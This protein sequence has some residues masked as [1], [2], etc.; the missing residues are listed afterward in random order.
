MCGTLLGSG[1]AAIN[2]WPSIEQWPSP[3]LTHTTGCRNVW[4][5]NKAW[6][7]MIIKAKRFSVTHGVLLMNCYNPPPSHPSKKKSL[8]VT[9]TS[10]L[11]ENTF[12]CTCN[13]EHDDSTANTECTF[14]TW[15]RKYRYLFIC[16]LY[17]QLWSLSRPNH[18][19]ISPRVPYTTETLKA[20]LNMATTY[21]QAQCISTNTH[22]S[23]GYVNMP[24]Y[25]FQDISNRLQ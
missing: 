1:N 19:H 21:M 20:K 10:Y 11:Q 17:V 23:A 24:F 25:L 5:W 22:K 9:A 13:S 14:L 6:A 15:H 3:W 2:H 18:V 16:K 7:G 4:M 12:F 8:P